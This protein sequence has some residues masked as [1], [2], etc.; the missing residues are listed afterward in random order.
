MKKVI[1]EIDMPELSM[2]E[3]PIEY[4]TEVGIF[5]DITFLKLPFI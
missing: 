5:Y 1:F 4:K 3:A 2:I